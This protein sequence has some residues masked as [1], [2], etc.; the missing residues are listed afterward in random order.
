MD[1]ML[2]KYGKDLT[3]D[4]YTREARYVIGYE[5][6]DRDVD[7]ILAEFSLERCADYF[8]RSRQ[9]RS[10]KLKATGVHDALPPRQDGAP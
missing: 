10:A 9:V 6:E 4:Y 1:A 7:A 3:F 5:K 2:A 8:N